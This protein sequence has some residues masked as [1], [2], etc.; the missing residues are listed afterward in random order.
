MSDV[1]L[2]EVEENVETQD[3]LVIEKDDTLG[4]YIIENGTCKVVNTDDQYVAQLLKKG[5][6][7]GESDITKS[8][9][10]GFFGSVIAESDEVECLFIPM[11]EFEKIP[12]FEQKIIQRHSLGRKEMS[13]L[14]FEYSKRYNI[15][16]DEYSSYYG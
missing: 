16:I 13:M 14:G 7:F 15:H 5:D 6:Y 10:F 12:L 4:I 9:G 2:N 8:V 3:T 11:D 1:Q